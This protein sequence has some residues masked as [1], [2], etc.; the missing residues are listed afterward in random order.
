MSKLENA[1]MQEGPWPRV[2]WR[3]RDWPTMGDGY[4]K[5][6]C[7]YY[8]LDPHDKAIKAEKNKS[9]GIIYLFRAMYPYSAWELDAR[10]GIPSAIKKRQPY[11]VYAACGFQTQQT[12]ASVPAN[13]QS[14][15]QPHWMQNPGQWQNHVAGCASDSHAQSIKTSGQDSSGSENDSSSQHSS[16]PATEKR[17][18]SQNQNKEDSQPVAR[19]RWN[20]AKPRPNI[21]CPSHGDSESEIQHRESK[22][23]LQAKAGLEKV[24][25]NAADVDTRSAASVTSASDSHAQSIKTSGQDSSGSENDSS[26]QHSSTP[27]TEKRKRSQNQ[28]KEDSQPVARRRWNSAKPRPNIECPSHGDSESEIQHRESKSELQAKAGLEKVRAN[29]ADVDTRSAASVTKSDEI[30]TS[31]LDDDTC[32]HRPP[33]K[34]KPCERPDEIWIIAGDDAL[35]PHFLDYLAEVATAETNWH[36]K[37]VRL[38][39][40]LVVH[41]G[42]AISQLLFAIDAGIIPT[43]KHMQVHC[44]VSECNLKVWPTT[45][46]AVHKQRLDNINFSLRAFC[47]DG[48]STRAIE[49]DQSAKSSGEFLLR[50][51][52]GSFVMIGDGV[53]GDIDTDTYKRRLTWLGKRALT[54]ENLA[55]EL[56]YAKFHLPRRAPNGV[57]LQN[58]SGIKMLVEHIASISGLGRHVLLL[59][60]SPS[61]DPIMP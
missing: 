16:T 20:S 29:A 23:E 11:L 56:V 14:D 30:G 8:G 25:A 46:Q 33:S 49:K 22:S 50:S 28:N 41:T 3:A 51:S 40:Q 48:Q 57:R 54:D 15:W 58:A 1:M 24:R 37:A 18:R 35:M 17:K 9:G 7:L 32:S 2:L 5:D 13:V 60:L 31:K 10:W 47:V 19:R 55:E 27:A 59:V 42:V 26:S 21:E 45:S 4:F 61:G 6:L 36:V 52:L 44:V 12:H 38:P 39:T 53:F 43:S 34:L